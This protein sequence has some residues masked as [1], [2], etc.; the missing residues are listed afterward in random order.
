MG[1]FT[2]PPCY[3]DGGKCPDR[4]EGCHARC[5]RYQEW[6]V[7]HENERQKRYNIYCNDRDLD[8]FECQQG[9]RIKRLNRA[10]TAQE[11]RRR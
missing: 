4:G 2:K 8:T 6:Q 7:I 3:V 9:L 1:Y 5:E 10:R 11:K